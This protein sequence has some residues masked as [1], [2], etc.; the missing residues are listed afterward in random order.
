MQQIDSG[1]CNTLLARYSSIYEQHGPGGLQREFATSVHGRTIFLCLQSTNNRLFLVNN[2]GDN[3]DIK[4]PDP[5]SF[6]PEHFGPWIHLEPQSTE[7]W[8]LASRKLPQQ[9]VLQI[10]LLTTASV[11]LYARL[12]SFLFITW[13]LLSPVALIPPWMMW[14]RY[15]KNTAAL[16]KKIEETA[17]EDGETRPLP[18][19]L[20]SGEREVLLAVDHLINRHQHM[21]GQMREAMDNVAHDL[22]TPMTRLK[23]IAEYGLQE[24]SDPNQL[25]ERLSDCLEEAD[26]LLSMLNAMLNVA[27]AE[28][29]S[30]NLN[31]QP[32]R[33]REILDE[34]VE[35]YTLVAEEKKCTLTIS[36]PNPVTANIDPARIGQVWANL[37]DNAIKYGATAV[38][39][40]LRQREN[41]GVVR[42][43]DNGRGISPTELPRIWDRLYRGDRSRS[44]PGLG[45]GL[46]LARAIINAHG[47]SVT[48]NSELNKGTIFTITL[49]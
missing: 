10:G 26:R 9:D 41:Q 45:L 48:V 20:P 12:Q 31:L 30:M 32:K 25:R 44:Q 33:L 4:I 15:K 39:I 11:Q 2:Q 16:A 22:R 14:R 17:L 5:T 24:Q 7:Y 6:T 38:S 37:I 18:S 28:A 3:P 19:S 36:E 49:P 42:I 27:E 21:L 35:V 46:T 34:V 43:S 29:E 23:T 1:H 47:G 40:D 13:L 8:T